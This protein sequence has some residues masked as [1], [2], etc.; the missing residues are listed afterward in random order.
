MEY[1]REMDMGTIL[2]RQ[3]PILYP[4]DYGLTIS[5][6][7]IYVYFRCIAPPRIFNLRVTGI[8]MGILTPMKL[9]SLVRLNQHPL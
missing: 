6:S 9:R 5:P 8:I 2:T 4:E 1:V 3:I 7:L